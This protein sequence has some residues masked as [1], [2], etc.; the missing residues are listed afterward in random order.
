MNKS[1]PHVDA[2][3]V[4]RATELKEE[5]NQLYAKGNTTEAIDRYTQALELNPKDHIVFCNR[6]QAYLSISEL[7]QAYSDAQNAINIKPDWAKGYQRKI[8]A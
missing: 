1:A 8:N 2:G 7:D 6:S 5:G 3:D 4:A